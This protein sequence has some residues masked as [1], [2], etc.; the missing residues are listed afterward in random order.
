MKRREPDP[1]FKGLPCSAVATGCAMQIANRSGIDALKSPLLKEDGYL[2]LKGMDTL[3]RQNL[4]VLKRINYRRGERP[5]LRD[6]AH[7]N[8]GQKAII[9]VTGHY[10][11]FDG[12]N[13]WSYF[14]NGSDDVVSVWM[15][16]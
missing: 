3:V 12:K 7:D 6:W 5:I 14:W 13:Y 16:R 1:I 10:I 11:Y 8:L 2:S 9:C 15:I 4:A